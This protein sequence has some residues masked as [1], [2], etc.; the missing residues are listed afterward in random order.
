MNI[1][2][3]KS[4][5]MEIISNGKFYYPAYSQ[6]GSNPIN[7]QCNLCTKPNLGS[8]I[9]LGKFN[10]CLECVD[11]LTSSKNPNPNLNNS[12]QQH[13]ATKS[14]QNI[15]QNIGQNIKMIRPSNDFNSSQYN[16]WEDQFATS[17]NPS[18]SNSNKYDGNL[19]TS[20][21]SLETFFQPLNPSTNSLKRR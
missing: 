1:S 12:N 9:G 7:I 4:N 20:A 6:Y 13:F 3:S 5:A 10:L 14:I 19:S 15:G 2:L 21:N 16:S 8:S 18:M 17:L 11:M